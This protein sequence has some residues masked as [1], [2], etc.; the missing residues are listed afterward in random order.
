[1]VIALYKADLNEIMIFFMLSI[2]YSCL[3]N[4]SV[5][6][7]NLNIIITKFFK[8]VFFLFVDLE[9]IKLAFLNVYRKRLLQ[10]F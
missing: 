8:F 1:M 7:T 3:C 6:N 2:G 9:F 10:Y 4:V 5:E